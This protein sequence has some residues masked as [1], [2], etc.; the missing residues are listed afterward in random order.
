MSKSRTRA[1]VGMVFA[2][3][4]IW[5]GTRTNDPRL[6]QAGWELLQRSVKEFRNTDARSDAAETHSA[7]SSSAGEDQALT[8]A[9]G[10]EE[11]A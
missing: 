3:M 5:S 7:P 2:R 9:H 8:A 6:V 11:P 10:S 1:N 4:T